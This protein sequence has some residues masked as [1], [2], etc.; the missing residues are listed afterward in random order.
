MNERQR[1]NKKE[2]KKFVRKRHIKIERENCRQDQTLLA[3]TTTARGKESNLYI[4]TGTLRKG[5][6]LIDKENQNGDRNI[7]TGTKMARCQKLKASK[8]SRKKKF[9]F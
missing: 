3:G 5:L 1:S 4:G 9:F 6:A 8:G 7:K 2:K